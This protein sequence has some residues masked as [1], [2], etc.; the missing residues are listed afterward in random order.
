[1]AERSTTFDHLSSRLSSEEREDL[2]TRIRD[3]F[4]IDELIED[5]SSTTSV[6][7]DLNIEYKKLGLFQRL[8]LLIKAVMTRRDIYKILEERLVERTARELERENPGLFNAR[9]RSIGGNLL[10]EIEPLKEA[11][12]YFAAPLIFAMGKQKPEFFSFLFALELPALHTNLSTTA[13]PEAVALD[14]SLTSEFDIKRQMQLGVQD[15]LSNLPESGRKTMYRYSRFLISLNELIYFPYAGLMDKLKTRDGKSGVNVEILRHDL[16]RLADIFASFCRF[17][18]E[19]PVQALFLYQSDADDSQEEPDYSE[20]LKKAAEAISVIRGFIRSVPLP[21]LL[22]VITKNLS[23]KTRD[24]GGGEDWLVLLRRYWEQEVEKNIGIYIYRLRR[25]EIIA[26]TKSF[27]QSEMYSPLQFYR[28]DFFRDVGGVKYELTTAFLAAFA[29]QNFRIEMLRTLKTFVVDSEFYKPQNRRD[30]TD[31]LEGLQEAPEAFAEF[32]RD[33]SSEGDTGKAISAGREIARENSERSDIVRE[34]LSQAN[35]K[36]LQLCQKTKEQLL[37]LVAV[38][39]GIL[40]G[41]SGGQ[42]DTISN[43][44]YIGGIDNERLILRLESVLE[45][46]EEAVALMNETFELEEFRRV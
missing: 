33:I 22:K 24:I 13:D 18:A 42:Y 31:S 9:D 43:K 36:A 1:M 15:V 29:G 27:F 4:E 39:K 37:L 7:D 25:T 8:L 30:F 38:T 6:A 21:K 26:K 5:E 34:L 35:A 11:V 16:G 45:R 20:I 44:G 12:N 46:A 40:F 23:F 19:T 3:S 2:L 32:D 10:Q 41:E 28:S 17:S 14:N